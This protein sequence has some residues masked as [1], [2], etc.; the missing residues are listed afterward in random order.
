MGKNNK[1]ETAPVQENEIN[2]IE[3]KIDDNLKL[4]KSAVESAIKEM[5]EKK[6]QGKI[7]DAK[8]VIGYA[9]YKR[10]T[11][12]LD[13]RKQRKIADAMKAHM[14]KVGELA[15]SVTEKYEISKPDFKLKV[16]ELED[17]LQKTF[18]KIDDEYKTSYHK[19]RREL[20]AVGCFYYDM[21]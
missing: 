2:D 14:V 5:E 17:E 12:L 11:T 6:Q 16:R 3:K 13:L 18:R 7:E 10:T 8:W 20:E 4:N 1:V 15:D 21:I 9:N 19:V